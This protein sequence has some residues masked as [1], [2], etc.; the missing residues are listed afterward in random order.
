MDANMTHSQVGLANSYAHGKPLAPLLRTSAIKATIM[1]LATAVSAT[2]ISNFLQQRGYAL[3]GYAAATHASFV[4]VVMLH[5]LLGTFYFAVARALAEEKAAGYV[6]SV[7]ERPGVRIQPSYWVRFICN[8][9]G[10][11][12]VFWIGSWIADNVQNFRVHGWPGLDGLV[13][14]KIGLGPSAF[15]GLACAIGWAICAGIEHIAE[16]A[17]LRY[18][19]IAWAVVSVVMGIF[20]AALYVAILGAFIW[21][22][23]WLVV[24][25]GGSTILT[26]LTVLGVV[27]I[28]L[29]CVSVTTRVFYLDGFGRIPL[30]RPR[31]WKPTDISTWDLPVETSH[32]GTL[33]NGYPYFIWREG[34]DNRLG[35]SRPRHCGIVVHGDQLLFGFYDPVATIRRGQWPRFGVLLATLIAVIML[36]DFVALPAVLGRAPYLSHPNTPFLGELVYIAVASAVSAFALTSAA[37]IIVTLA[38][39]R[40]N[41]FATDGWFETRPLRELTGFDMPPAGNLRVEDD[42]GSAPANSFGLTAVFDDGHMW[43]LTANAWNYQTAARYH[44]ILTAA[45]RDTRDKFTSEFEA[46]RKSSAS[47]TPLPAQGGVN[48]RDPLRNNSGLPETL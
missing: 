41:R 39:W 5:V 2:V 19:R 10:V 38:R 35:L 26:A 23:D 48:R 28:A 20:I 11:G 7:D 13:P 15:F 31:T 9:F 37:Y 44:A 18:I 27:P 34:A 33:P 25:F 16:A 40:L 3:G 29:T 30:E 1:G 42:N 8:W 4:F 6:P 17:G 22:I 21:V 46:K 47:M 32:S 45:F 14:G 36:I 24:R 43:V 12:L